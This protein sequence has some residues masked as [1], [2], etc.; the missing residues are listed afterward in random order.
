MTTTATPDAL[1]LML[2]RTR[3]TARLL[4]RAEEALA[5]ASETFDIDDADLLVGIAARAVDRIIGRLEL[6]TGA[7]EVGEGVELAEPAEPQPTFTTL[8]APMAR[9]MAADEAADL[10]RAREAVEQAVSY[11]RRAAPGG[12][13]VFL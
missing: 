3:A 6:A 8:S 4:A 12:D 5:G 11:E 13:A 1:L 2:A 9:A 10:R 7:V